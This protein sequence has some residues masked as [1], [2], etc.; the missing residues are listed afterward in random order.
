VGD[1]LRRNLTAIPHASEQQRD[2]CSKRP[3]V[4]V[5]FVKHHEPQGRTKKLPVLW[6]AEHVLQHRVVRDD[7]I[8]DVPPGGF[9][10]PRA[11]GLP[12]LHLFHLSILFRGFAC[13][14]KKTEPLLILEKSI[15]PGHLVGDERVHGIENQTTHPR[16]VACSWPIPEPGKYR[17]KKGFRLSCPCTGGYHKRRPILWRGDRVATE[18]FGLIREQLAV[19]RESAAVAQAVQIFAKVWGEEAVGCE[20]FQRIT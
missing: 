20:R 15:Q 6:A 7:D 2:F 18:D 14:M 17:Q 10:T 9:A 13:E 3:G 19:F 11:T 16:F 1:T 8:R 4:Q 12:L 5:G